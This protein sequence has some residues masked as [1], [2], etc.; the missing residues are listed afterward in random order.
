MSET[1][2]PMLNW[3]DIEKVIAIAEHRFEKSIKAV[4][5]N[6]KSAGKVDPTLSIVR[7]GILGQPMVVE[8]TIDETVS[9]TK[10]IQNA[11]GLFHQDILGTV[12][13]WSSSGT[14]GGSIDLRG[15]SPITKKSIIA[16]VKMRWNTIK[17]SDEKNI[18][19]DLKHAVSLTGSDS[20]G[21][22]F[23]II[24]KT[25]TAYDTP[26]KVSGRESN[27]KIRC[28]D[29]VTAYHLVTGKPDALSE[30]LTI[31]PHVMTEAV[32][33]ILGNGNNARI[34]FKNSEPIVK[35]IIAGNLPPKS[36]HS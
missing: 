14:S 13:G 1:K 23:Q 17:A 28:A 36:A 16:E 30:L 24:P 10:T 18:W 31:L 8:D 9:I 5:E 33:N 32:T 20:I 21:Y 25:N 15:T 34:A 3:I 12:T 19:D 35:Q 26:W 29:G 6:A 4:Q 22:V 11:V 27:E 2:T 7:A